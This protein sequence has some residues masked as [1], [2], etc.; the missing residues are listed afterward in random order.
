MR[1]ESGVID[2]F[3]L[4]KIII[5]NNYKCVNHFYALIKN[6]IIILS[7]SIKCII[8]LSKSEYIIWKKLHIT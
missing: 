2:L 5:I 6:Y 3:M 7:F 8:K 1:F 4:S